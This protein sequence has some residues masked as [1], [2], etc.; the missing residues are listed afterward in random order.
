M[1]ILEYDSDVLK[2]EF[3]LS[4]ISDTKKT[5]A[6]IFFQFSNEHLEITCTH[7]HGQNTPLFFTFTLEKNA[8]NA[9][10][11]VIKL[12]KATQLSFCLKKNNFPNICFDQKTF[13][14]TFVD[15]ISKLVYKWNSTQA[16]VHPLTTLV[17]IIFFQKYLII[18][19]KIW[20]RFFWPKKFTKTKFFDFA[21]SPQKSFRNILASLWPQKSTATRDFCTR[22]TCICWIEKNGNLRMQFWAPPTS[23]GELYTSPAH[24]IL[25]SGSFEREN[26][27]LK[28]EFFLFSEG[29]LS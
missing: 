21:K 4:H 25:Q 14:E 5:F 1:L 9:C 2:S 24:T 7:S 13:G 23:G 6:T 17:K 22:K 8:K 27:N 3:S 29:A 10:R 19:P 28:I 15:I 18:W 16:V 26:C 12:D 11:Y 20:D